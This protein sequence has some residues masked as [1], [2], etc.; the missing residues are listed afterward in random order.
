MFGFGRK[1]PARPVPGADFREANQRASD[2]LAKAAKT[3][4]VL[5]RLD[6]DSQG[7]VLSSRAVDPP[8]IA[9]FVRAELILVDARTQARL[10]DPPPRSEDSEVRQLAAKVARALRFQPAKRG[11][12]PTSHRGYRTTISF[13][14][15]DKT[16]GSA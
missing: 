12:R 9:R 5:V 13:G 4:S 10:P 1:T 6:I 3:G 16:V 8:W 14:Q 15:R 2:Q 11:S 7:R